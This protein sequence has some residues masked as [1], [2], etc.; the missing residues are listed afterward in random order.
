M[1]L[2]YTDLPFKYYR[3]GKGWT[4]NPRGAFRDPSFPIPPPS[5][6]SRPPRV[7]ALPL[8]MEATSQVGKDVRDAIE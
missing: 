3:V 5:L 4:Y 7:V 8:E 1:H 6:V 2:D